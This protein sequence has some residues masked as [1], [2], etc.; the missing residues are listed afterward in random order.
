MKYLVMIL[1]S[2]LTLALMV[3]AIIFVSNRFA[4]YFPVLSYNEWLWIMGSVL[5]LMMVGQVFS[6]SPNI[7]GRFISNFSSI[8]SAVVFYLFISVV[9]IELFSLLFHFTP[10]YRGLI[11][12]ALA[13]IILVYGIFNAY[14]L[15]VNHIT[16]P[17]EGLTKEKKAVHI[18]DIHLGNF[19]GEDYLDKI[20]D[21]INELQPNIVFNTGDQFDS[22]AHFS[23]NKI[24]QAYKRLKVP[25]YF[26]YGNHDVY[27][28]VEEV[29]AR[30]KATGAVV[31]QN[32]V[33]NF[34]ELQIVGLNNMLQNSKTF[35]VH[36]TPGDETVESVM[37]KLPINESRPTIV[38]HHRP[39]GV[40]YMSAR[41]ADLLLSGHTHGGQ[42][43]PITYIAKLMF[44]YNSGLYEYNN[45]TIHVSN[46]A[47][48]IFAPLRLGTGSE[49]T[50][51]KLI[52][53]K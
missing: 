51:I 27:V 50:L 29:V 1:M 39:D 47:G 32:E 16:I 7:A 4:L 11:S 33:S 31:L 44:K 42:A 45:M 40:K 10:V 53:K 48:S 35:D 9:A 28:G 19:R 3:G 46:G 8:A 18:T 49:I 43:F 13:A 6:V 22:K 14:S 12:L 17:I 21:R 37:A 5:V 34:G 36:A 15:K 24:L 26:V 30:M 52:S 20:V 23:D 25:H 41:K 38:L 2:V